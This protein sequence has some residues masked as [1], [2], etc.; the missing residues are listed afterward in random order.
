[1]ALPPS[2]AD[3][4]WPVRTVARQIGAW[5]GRLGAVWVEGQVAQLDRRPGA[6]V[7]FLTL[8]DTAADLSLSLT[9]PASLLAQAE[10][11]VAEGQRIVVLAQPEVWL[12]RGRLQLAV[13]ELRTVGLGALL[14]RLEQLKTLLGQEGLFDVDRKKPLPFLPRAVGLVCG[15]ESAARRDVVEHATAR[16]PAVRFEVREVPVQ[17]PN[18]VA[19]VIEALRELDRA[20]GVDVIVVARGGG[21]VE[22]LLPFSDESLCRAVA[23]CLTPVVTAIGHE[24]DTPLVDFVADRRASTPTDAGKLVVP[25]V[26]EEAARI[27]RLRAAAGRSVLS[28]LDREQGWL[29]ACRSRPVLATPDVGVR[30]WAAEVV[31]LRARARRA[32]ASCVDRDERSLAAQ[33]AQITALSPAATLERGYAVVQRPDGSVLRDAATV[34]RGE[35]LGVRLSRGRLD[36]EVVTASAVDGEGEDERDE[37]RRDG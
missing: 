24:Q 32:V 6:A 17:G 20:R 18:A 34:T 31:D 36:A 29:T 2:T 27:A 19:S 25:D 15:R 3:E 33:R 21:S 12:S 9:V 14:A 5:V 37:T 22:D 8:R 23:S 26:G 10:T 4:P 30:R 13:R 7:A 11:P 28:R 16:W 35:R 1:M